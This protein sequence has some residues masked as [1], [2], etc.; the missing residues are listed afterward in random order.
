MKN[1]HYY[2]KIYDTSEA[3]KAH[4]S[5]SIY[6]PIYKR[7]TEKL[8]QGSK[9]LELGC[10]S[11]HLAHLL[12]YNGFEYYLGLDFSQVAIDYAKKR[13][14][15][16]FLKQDI[17]NGNVWSNYNVSIAL[18]VFEHIEY[19]KVLRKLKKHSRI[20]FSV[21]NFLI[22]S[23][24]YSWQNKGEI[25]KDFEKYVDI[26][27]IEIPLQIKGKTWFLIDGKIK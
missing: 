24:I 23:H 19:E 7:V 26:E 9:I 20:L 1:E 3:Y 11:G 27:S 12:K 2:N 8:T 16:E 14:N 5:D 15:Q 13:T 4:Y 22:D 25:K 6:Y 10:G 17:L 18:E 21:P